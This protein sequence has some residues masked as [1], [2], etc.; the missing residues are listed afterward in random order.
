MKIRLIWLT[1]VLLLAQGCATYHSR[2]YYQPEP[3]PRCFGDVCIAAR[4]FSYQDEKGDSEKWLARDSFYV[5]FRVSD[6]S[7]KLTDDDLRKSEEERRQDID[8]FR[9]RVFRSFVVDSLVLRD[10]SQVRLMSLRLDTARFAP[11]A[12]NTFTL[13]FGWVKLPESVTRM[14][15]IIHLNRLDGG[16]A[17]LPDSALFVM[18]REEYHEKGVE[19]LRDNVRGYEE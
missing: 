1:M 11:Q 19:L 5:S 9:Q 16:A 6:E 7:I 12:A 8:A 14:R 2:F 3:T 4:A 13:N 10:N 18:D 15:A 17:P